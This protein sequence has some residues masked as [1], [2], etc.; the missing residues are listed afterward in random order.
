MSH[1]RVYQTVRELTAEQRAAS[2]PGT[3]R[4]VDRRLEI[5]RS[6]PARFAEHGSVDVGVETNGHRQRSTEWPYDVG[7]APARLWRR[8]DVSV[9]GSAVAQLKRSKATY[10]QG[11]NLGL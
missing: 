5:S 7:V 2:D 6:A 3:D 4:D 1:L 11:I 8:R 10:P 9:A